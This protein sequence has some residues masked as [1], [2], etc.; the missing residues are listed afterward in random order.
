MA[1]LWTRALAVVYA[2]FC[3]TNN[4]W[5]VIYWLSLL[6]FPRPRPYSHNARQWVQKRRSERCKAT[7]TKPLSFPTG[8]SYVLVNGKIAVDH[9]H[10]TAELAGKLLRNSRR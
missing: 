6:P 8:I 7:F 9:G 5:V 4:P 1:T 2:C 10:Q 3:A